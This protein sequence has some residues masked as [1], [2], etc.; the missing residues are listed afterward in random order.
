MYGT[1]SPEQICL[2]LQELGIDTIA[3]TDING[4]YGLHF[5]LD[6]ARHYKIK[7]IIGTEII[8]ENERALLLA[9]NEK[10]YREICKCLTRKYN[11]ENFR[12]QEY[13][14]EHNKDVIILTDNK[15][16]LSELKDCPDVYV[17]LQ[18]Y[19]DHHTLQKIAHENN[20][21]MVGMSKDSIKKL[22]KALGE[23][24]VVKNPIDL[25]GDADSERYKVALEFCLE[26]NEIDIVLVVLLYQMPLITTDIVDIITEAKEKSS[27]PIVVVSTGGKFTEVMKQSLEKNGVPCFTFPKNAVKAIAKLVEYYSKQ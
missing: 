16:L 20:L 18:A 3:L 1:A 6:E 26:E 4:L 7:V 19:R 5:F 10:G 11:D 8:H 27:K 24:V 17:E 25:L 9:K 22:Q 15:N 21:E 2:R 23:M 13:L 14:K 12:L